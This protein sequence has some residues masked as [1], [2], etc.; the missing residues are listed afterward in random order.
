MARPLNFAVGAAVVV[1]LAAF[2]SADAQAG[3][4]HVTCDEVR[5]VRAEA[6]AQGLNDRTLATLERQVCDRRDRGRRGNKG[7][8]G[9]R[10]DEGRRGQRP[11]PQDWR[12]DAFEAHG[13]IPQDCQDLEVVEMLQR[14]GGQ[15]RRQAFDELHLLMCELGGTERALY[16]NGQ[17]AQFSYGWNWPN[18]KTAKR[19][20]GWNFP[21]GK[22]AVRSFGYNWPNGKTAKRSFGWN[23]PN[24]R[25]AKRSFGWS[26]PDG[27]RAGNERDVLIWAC[28][29]VG[30]KKCRRRV[31]RIE[32]MHGDARDAAIVAFVW[33]ASRG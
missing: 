26:L 33:R 15:P 20:F 4:P 31:N 10:Y 2:A 18:G 32:N 29:R 12:F 16:S 1:V 11:A 14:V 27:R 8:R 7:R 23:Y 28:Q 30:N 25:T 9:G 5:R 13:P 24:G 17:R 22:T 6:T 21:N 3:R 19:S